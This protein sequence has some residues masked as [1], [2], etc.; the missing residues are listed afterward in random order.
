MSVSVDLPADA[1]RRLE[2]EAARRVTS[3]DEI[4]AELAGRLPAERPGTLHR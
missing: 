4:I 1:L 3:I 2:A